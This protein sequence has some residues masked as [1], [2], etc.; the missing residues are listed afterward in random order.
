MFIILKL[1]P[2]GHEKNK[3]NIQKYNLKEIHKKIKWYKHNTDKKVP[4]I[5][6]GM[7][8]CKIQI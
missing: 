5:K 8:I 7:Y 6:M 4:D 3:T 1:R 2:I